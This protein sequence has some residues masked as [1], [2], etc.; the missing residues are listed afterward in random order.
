MQS[1]TRGVFGGGTNPP[2]S[3]VNTM[4]YLLQLSTLGNAADFGD[5]TE[6]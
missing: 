4:V 1:P 2:G 6:Q 3:A 5:L